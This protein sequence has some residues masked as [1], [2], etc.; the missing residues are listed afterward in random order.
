MEV[1]KK[2][3]KVIT[4]MPVT[5]SAYGDNSD[6]NT[7]QVKKW[8]NNEFLS[9]LTRTDLI[10]PKTY[11]LDQVIASTESVVQDATYTI[12]K[13]NSHTKINDCQNQI[14]ESI[15]LM[16]FEDYVYSYDATN[17]NY[18]LANYLCG[19]DLEWTMSSY[20]NDQMW[21]T[22]RQEELLVGRE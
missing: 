18:T 10:V 8:L 21:I 4:S 3:I 12:Q 19:D 20:D 2:D 15:G 22:W 5:S 14:T 6:Y 7:A 11:C 9:V 13:V 1:N 17:P 16:T